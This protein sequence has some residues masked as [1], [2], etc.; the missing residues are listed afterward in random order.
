M[1]NFK[2]GDKVFIKKSTDR[3]VVEIPFTL[4]AQT[5]FHPSGGN[6]S[7]YFE[8]GGWGYENDFTINNSEERAKIE[9]LK[10]LAAFIALIPEGTRAPTWAIS[11]EGFADAYR[12]YR[13]NKPSAA[14]EAAENKA[15]ALEAEARH[16]RDTY[17]ITKS[18]E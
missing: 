11:R 1:S 12:R 6:P 5:S 13:D 18:K 4:Q 8:E 10:H 15:L 9:F 14:V 16:I 3:G 17:R 7:W 2:P